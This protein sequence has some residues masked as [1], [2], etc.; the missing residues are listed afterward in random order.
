MACWSHDCSS[1]FLFYHFSSS[2]VY[3]GLRHVFFFLISISLSSFLCLFCLFVFVSFGNKHLIVLVFI[4]ANDNK[5]S[6]FHDL[7]VICKGMHRNYGLKKQSMFEYNRNEDERGI[8]NK[9]NHKK[10]YHVSFFYIT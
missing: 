1:T 4:L 9:K 2:F 6:C 3:G 10:K 5:D 7:F 8:Y